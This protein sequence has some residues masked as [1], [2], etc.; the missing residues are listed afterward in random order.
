MNSYNGDMIRALPIIVLIA[1]TIYTIVHVVQSNSERVRGLPKVLWL[2]I[3]LFVPA[4]GVIAWWMFGRPQSTQL[5]PPT[6]PDDDPLF[7][8][9]L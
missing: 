8:R 6:A 1:C 9:R 4:L 7:L 5:P 3:V 2:I